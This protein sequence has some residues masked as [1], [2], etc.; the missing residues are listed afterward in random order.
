MAIT[1]GI[2]HYHLSTVICVGGGSVGCCIATDK[3]Y[4]TLISILF[5]K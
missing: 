4:T 3:P 1:T 5:K 2:N